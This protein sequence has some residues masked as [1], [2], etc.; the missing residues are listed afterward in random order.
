M[1]DPLFTCTR[2]KINKKLN[3]NCKSLIKFSQV[4]QF[5]QIQNLPIPLS[6]D[7]SRERK[8]RKKKTQLKLQSQHAI[9]A[10]EHT[11]NPTHVVLHIR[12]PILLWLPRIPICLD[13]NRL[14]P[15]T[16]RTRTTTIAVQC[17][18]ETAQHRKIGTGS[19]H[20]SIEHVLEMGLAGGLC[21][22]QREAQ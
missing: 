20:R 15:T 11:H 19:V 16:T 12:D 13:L 22:V 7:F 9:E 3:R 18:F 5:S 8:R 4:S 14:P 1:L 21:P 2:K 17:R 6:R 10:I